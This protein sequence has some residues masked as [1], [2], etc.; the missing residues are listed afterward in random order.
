MTDPLG[1]AV[2]LGGGVKAVCDGYQMHI[3]A[4]P[5]GPVSLDADQIH[6]IN[7]L[8]IKHKMIKEEAPNLYEGEDE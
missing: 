6:M 1:G 8:A 2:Y 7:E 3:I 4:T 5:D